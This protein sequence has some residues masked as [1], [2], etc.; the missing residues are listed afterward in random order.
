MSVM[1]LVF[2]TKQTTKE[3]MRGYKRNIDRTIRDLD[4]EKIKMANEEKRI[5]GEMKKS[6]IIIT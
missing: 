5:V 6:F 1:E 4:R 3:I 2:G